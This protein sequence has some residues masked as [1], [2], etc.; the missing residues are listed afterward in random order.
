MDGV[1]VIDATKKWRVRE[2]AVGV[3]RG[4]FGMFEKNPQVPANGAW[5]CATKTGRCRS[6]GKVVAWAIY[7]T[8]LASMGRSSNMTCRIAGPSVTSN[9]AG[10]IKKNKGKISFTPT[11]RVFSRT[12]CRIRHLR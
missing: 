12:L 6:W 2:N 11:L 3:M 1:A 7:G 4:G 9:S 10:K 5:H 8:A